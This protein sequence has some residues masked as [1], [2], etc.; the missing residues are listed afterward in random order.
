MALVQHY[1]YYGRDNSIS[2][3]YYL[4]TR[5]KAFQ[6]TLQT[7]ARDNSELYSCDYPFPRVVPAHL[8]GVV[9]EDHVR[10]NLGGNC[11]DWGADSIPQSG[12]M[13]SLWGGTKIE[14][15]PYQGTITWIFN[16]DDDFWYPAVFSN[17]ASTDRLFNDWVGYD[18]S[19]PENRRFPLG[20]QVESLNQAA[21]KSVW[22]ATTTARVLVQNSAV[23]KQSAEDTKGL[24]L[25]RRCV[26][27]DTYDIGW[28]SIPPKAAE[29]VI[30]LNDAP[31]PPNF[32]W[33]GIGSVVSIWKT[34]Q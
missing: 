18:N 15:D 6:I 31:L 34:T 27:P 23:L 4:Q 24:A 3:Y 17:T 25:T 20:I 28:C 22:S 29:E 16:T 33:V 5:I 13:P 11:L 32:H 9:T 19:A 14:F 26:E 8:K 2:D 1:Y 7:D 10:R 30:K 21:E 12:Y